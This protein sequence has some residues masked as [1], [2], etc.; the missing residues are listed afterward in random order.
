MARAGEK[1]LIDVCG[2]AV[3]VGGILFEGPSKEDLLATRLA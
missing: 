2:F 3:A 1:T